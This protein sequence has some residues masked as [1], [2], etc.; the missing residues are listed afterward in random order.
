MTRRIL[1]VFFVTAA[2]FAL[3]LRAEVPDAKPA[4][5]MTPACAR[6]Q[7]PQSPG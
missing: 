1:A 3:T 5:P 4:A 2:A 6:R 7:G